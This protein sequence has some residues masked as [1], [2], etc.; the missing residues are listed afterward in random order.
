MSGK[1]SLKL[2]TTSVL[3]PA[4]IENEALKKQVEQLNME[5]LVLRAKLSEA[6]VALAERK[7]CCDACNVNFLDEEI[8]KFKLAPESDYWL[9]QSCHHQA[10]LDQQAQ[11][12]HDEDDDESVCSHCPSDMSEDCGCEHCKECGGCRQCNECSCENHIYEVNGEI[13]SCRKEF[14]PCYGGCG[15]LFST[16]NEDLWENDC[17]CDECEEG[18]CRQCDGCGICDDCWGKGKRGDAT[19]Q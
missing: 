19:N 4:N 12:Y 10:K 18:N 3:H 16:E 7:D 9:C 8:D 6:L 13:R 2:K 5:N 14:I 11:Q 17:E 1:L 15:K